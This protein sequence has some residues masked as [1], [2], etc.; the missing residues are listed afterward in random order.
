MPGACVV[1]SVTASAAGEDDEG[2]AHDADDADDPDEADLVAHEMLRM[3]RAVTARV[4][5]NL[6]VMAGN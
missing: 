4:R 5:V 6:E 1:T 3:S 2:D